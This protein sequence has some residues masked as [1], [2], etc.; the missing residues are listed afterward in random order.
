MLQLTQQNSLL[1]NL[2]ALQKGEEV[3]FANGESSLFLI[4][5]REQKTIEAE[6]KTIELKAKYQKSAIG[7]RWAAGLLIN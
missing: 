5:A 2:H 4:N 3:R 6:Q 1:E 7:V